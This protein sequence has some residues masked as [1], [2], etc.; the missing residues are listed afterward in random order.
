MS[1]PGTGWERGRRVIFNDIAADYDKIRPDYPPELFTDIFN[2]SGTNGRKALEVG[3]GTGKATVPFL[4]AGYNVTAVELGAN[5]AEFLAE[6]FKESKSFSVITSAFEDAALDENSFDLIYAA[7]SFHW[8]DAEIG[9][10]KA[11][12]LLKNGGAITLFR[13]NWDHPDGDEL[14]EE[15]QEIYKQY[16]HKPYIRPLKVTGDE[17]WSPDGIIRGF[18]FEDLRNYGFTD[19]SMKLYDNRKIYTTDEYLAFLDTLSDHRSLPESDRADLY[20]SVREAIDK[21]GGFYKVDYVYQLYM[22]RKFLNNI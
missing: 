10:P 2:Y 7:S 14:Y 17:Y 5:M 8:V 9:C 6:R 11:F 16:Y 22:G 12:L 19:I 18:R 3:A 15:I 21:H 20:A 4:N 13:Y 1:D